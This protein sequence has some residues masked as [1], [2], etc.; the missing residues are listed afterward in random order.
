[1]K[2]AQLCCNNFAHTELHPEVLTSPRL[3]LTSTIDLHALIYLS[4][5]IATD[6]ERCL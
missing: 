2:N 5:D 3:L 4:I 1:M 6:E